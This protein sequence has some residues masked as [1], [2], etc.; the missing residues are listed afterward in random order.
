MHQT[1]QSTQ[2]CGDVEAPER[3]KHDLIGRWRDG[4][5]TMF[6][7]ALTNQEIHRLVRC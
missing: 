5:D 1:E 4:R 7:V 2:K 6:G 3:S